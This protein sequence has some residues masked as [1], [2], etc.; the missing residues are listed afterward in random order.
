[1]Q[2]IPLGDYVLL[3][4][5]HSGTP[6]EIFKASKT[7]DEEPA[8]CVAIKRLLPSLIGNEGAESALRQELETVSHLDHKNLARVADSGRIGDVL[9]MATEFVDGRSLR[10]IFLQ[11]RNRGGRLPLAIPCYIA[12]QICEGLQY[13]HEKKGPSGSPLNLVH[14]GIAPQHVLVSYDGEVKIVGFSRIRSANKRG[15]KLLKGDQWIPGYMSPEQMQGLIPDRRSDIFCV[16]IC[17]YELLTG[18][19]LF[20]ENNEP[21]TLQKINQVNITPPRSINRQIPEN[22][23]NSPNSAGEEEVGSF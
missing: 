13:I 2:S 18:E 17:L 5:I 6:T 1:M 15:D 9:F 11:Q 3:E 7:G 10:D 19:R 23:E 4:K 12:T 21:S 8:Q 22:L 14:C 20:S 16:G